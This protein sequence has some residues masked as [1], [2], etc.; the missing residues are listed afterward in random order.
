MLNI[1]ILRCGN[2]EVMH[3]KLGRADV[4]FRPSQ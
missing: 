3:P 4:Y 1:S 2:I